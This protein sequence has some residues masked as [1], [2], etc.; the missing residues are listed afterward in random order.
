MKIEVDGQQVE[1]DDGFATLSPEEQNATVDE[2]A[3][4]LKSAPNP[5]PA[6][7]PRDSRSP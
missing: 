1:I 2:I 6:R 4:S 3:A 7:C 5:A